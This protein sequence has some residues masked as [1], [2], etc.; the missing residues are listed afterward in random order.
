MLQ[1]ES[2]SADTCAESGYGEECAKQ[3][4]RTFAI[5]IAAVQTGMDDGSI[6]AD[7]DPTHIAVTLYGLSTGLLQVLS[8]KEHMLQ[9]ASPADLVETFFDLIYRSL[10]AQ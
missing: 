8:T 2:S 9:E 4:T 1:F 6:R 3:S 5:C 10:R 7:V